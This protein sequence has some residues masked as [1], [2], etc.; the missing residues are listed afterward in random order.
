M[1]DKISVIV[2]VYN[3]ELYLEECL[4]SIIG[5]S[6]Q[7][8]EIILV[9]D[10]STD[11]S[12]QMMQEFAERDSRIQIITQA[13]SGASSARNNGISKATGEYIL[14]VDSDDFIENDA[15]EVFYRRTIETQ[16]D[17]TI[18]NLRYYYPNG[19][20]IP[21]F[22]RT[23][24]L[25]DIT[26]EGADCFIRLIEN[27]VFPPLVPIYFIRRRF[28]IDNKLY[29][30]EGV[31][32]EDEL[33]CLKVLCHASR[34]SL[35]QSFHYLYRQR[36]GSVMNSKNLEFR[37]QSYYIVAKEIDCF[38]RSFSIE[39]PL[40]MKELFGCV[41]TKVFRLFCDMASLPGAQIKEECF[42]FFTDLLIDIYPK[43]LSNHQRE[44]LN[45]YRSAI[46]KMSKYAFEN[47]RCISI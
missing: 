45:W 25:N 30:K 2:P 9:D 17:I 22:R 43:I 5:Q 3:V 42:D 14:F 32:H 18:G 23:K 1:K 27:N 15:V 41:Y 4:Q 16:S 39:N 46:R 20:K 21:I 19:Y 11:K 8:L 36:E 47:Y 37:I 33:W 7:N 26:I 29:F 13:N 38:I 35:F 34:V 40:T 6:Y 44:C 12:P 31:M 28:I 10:G 24:E